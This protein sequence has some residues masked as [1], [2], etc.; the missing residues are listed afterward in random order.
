MQRGESILI[1]AGTGGVG[2]AA[3]QVAKHLGLKIFATAGTP[4]KRELLTA[5]GVGHVMSSRT[6]AFADEVMDATGGRGVDAVLNSLAGDFIP[7]S[8]S[9]LAPFG[10]FLEIGKVDIYRNAKI[11]LQPLK[12]NISYF[13]IDLT[14]HLRDR[15]EFVVQMFREIADGF[16][17]GYY[18]PVPLNLF[19]IAEV[20][21][22]FRFMA[23]GK[24]VGKNVLT[25]D[26][27]DTPV[28]FTTDAR[29]RFRSDATYLITGGAG[30]FGLELA[31]WIASHGG[32]H[33]VVMS[34]SG[35]RQDEATATIERLRSEGLMISDL[36]G[37][38][39]SPADVA[40]V[41]DTI[42]RELPPL[43]G[44]FHGAMVLDDGLIAELDAGRVRNA[45]APKMAGAWNLHLATRGMQLDHFVCFS[46]FSSVVGMIRQSN[47]N[48]G[49]AFL[50]SLAGYRRARN[51]PGLTINWGVILGA[52]YVE[53]TRNTA[54]V[55]ARAGV[56][57]FQADEALRAPQLEL[58]E[59]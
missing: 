17:A 58:E 28:A 24:H 29:H 11:G 48:A 41:L 53:R 16:A 21:D 10:R 6:L 23:Q 56:G 55:L 51:L 25:F 43:K 7:K 59:A 52:G 27:A 9:I 32:R 40:R 36:R 30:G 46:S 22:A 4:E 26:H 45:I 39:S 13:V 54:E 57:A 38:V 50:D 35:P 20:V 15:R 31:R 1:H 18:Q 34:R 49:N 37:D 12:D 3:I 8:L 42:A 19:P 47:Y 14:Q 33:I 44:V 2:Q 5:M